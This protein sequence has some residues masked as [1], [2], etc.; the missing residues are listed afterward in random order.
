MFISKIFFIYFILVLHFHSTSQI[1][2]KEGLSFSDIYNILL[3]KEK[4]NLIKIAIAG[5]DSESTLQC[6][7]KIKDLKIANSI[8]VGPEY[9]IKSIAQKINIDISD[10]EIINI[11]DD[12]EAARYA[13]KLVH[14]KKAD[15]YMKGSI[16]TKKIF[17]AIL[18]KEIGL[19]EKGEMNV[20]SVFEDEINK[21]LLLISDGSVRPYP[22]LNE[23]K[24]IIENAVNVAHS[25]KINNPKVAPLAAIEVV[26]EK[27]KETVEAKEL[28][29]M[30]EK[31]EIKGCIVDG[32]LSLD[33]AIDPEAARIKKINR[34]IMGDADILIFPDIHAGNIGYKML[35]HIMNWKVGNVVTGTNAPVILTSRG[36]NVETKINSI[37][38]TYMY[39]Q[40]KRNKNGK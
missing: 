38:V 12:T 31:G 27:M 10:F 39:F 24:L 5:A 21:K 8:L 14:D 4:N 1:S 35:T 28:Q 25:L 26:N 16:H 20:V 11:I 3:S 13:V 40:Y 6:A 30:N 34:K 36:D 37:L 7:R 29:K 23:K 9:H 2:L 22:T 15:I 18:D 33:L 19:K 32:P 17:K